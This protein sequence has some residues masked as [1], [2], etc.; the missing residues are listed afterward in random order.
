[1]GMISSYPINFIPLYTNHPSMEE[2]YNTSSIALLL[3]EGDEKGT[4]RLGL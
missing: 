4:R 3:V 2:G 1:L